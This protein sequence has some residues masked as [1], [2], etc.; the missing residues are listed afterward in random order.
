VS[1]SAGMSSEPITRWWWQIPPAVLYRE[2]RLN[3]SWYLLA[4]V[5]MLGAWVLPWI[6]SVFQPRYFAQMAQQVV[7]DYPFLPPLALP[8]LNCIVMGILA[9]MVFQN[10]WTRGQIGRVLEGPVRRSDVLSAKLGLLLATLVAYALIVFIGLA[11]FAVIARSTG[12]IGY[13]GSW[14]LLAT[15]MGSATAILALAAGTAM[16]N[17]IL[18][19]LTTAI[20]V[21][22][23]KV[24]SGIIATATPL[25]HLPGGVVVSPPNPWAIAVDRLSP[26]PNSE[27]AD[28]LILFALYFLVSTVF[29]GYRAFKWWNAVP[30]ER[31][32]STFFYPQLWNFYYA[33]L[34]LVS[35]F[36]MALILSQPL[37]P[38]RGIP[39]YVSF[40][41]LSVF[42]WFFWRAMYRRR[43][44]PPNLAARRRTRMDEGNT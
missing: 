25:V 20:W 17:P 31:F 10:D 16:S 27:P 41:T 34:A 43:R 4:F 39:F 38:Q 14:D 33:L 19:G 11:V 35:A 32:G 6:G 42:A 13:V 2:W 5:I 36:V 28:H 44:R 18:V 8:E 26:F 12:R 15:L 21:V 23:P 7:A 24:I 1:Q 9:V 29:I 30:T 22:V 37:M 3:R 40:G